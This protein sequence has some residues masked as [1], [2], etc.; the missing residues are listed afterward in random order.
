MEENNMEDRKY[1]TRDGQEIPKEQI[2]EL[3]KEGYVLMSQK[4]V[5]LD[6][7]ETNKKD[8]ERQR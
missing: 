8:E 5:I 1:Y 7:K 6:F 3:D 4:L 2:V